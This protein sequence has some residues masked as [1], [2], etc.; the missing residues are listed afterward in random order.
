[1]NWI[2]EGLEM[3]NTGKARTKF[4]IGPKIALTVKNS[5]FFQHISSFF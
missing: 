3:T 1:M 5:D 4:L 2:N